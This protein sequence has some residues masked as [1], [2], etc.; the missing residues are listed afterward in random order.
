MRVMIIRKSDQRTEAGELPNEEMLAAMGKYVR[1]VSDAG[2][3]LAGEG[4]KPSSASKRVTFANGKPH[5]IDGPF[6]ETKELIG[7][8][9]LIQVKSMEE[10][11]EWA[12][13]WPALDARGGVQLEIRPLYEPDDFGEE[14]TPELRREQAEVRAKVGG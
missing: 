2:I 10:A 13:R 14:Y 4:L 1:E 7:G 6:A 11:I 8:Y 3:F 9:L 5:V 12:K